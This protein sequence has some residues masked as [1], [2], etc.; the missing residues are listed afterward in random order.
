VFNR[1]VCRFLVANC[2]EIEQKLWEVWIEYHLRPQVHYDF[3]CD[4]FYKATIVVNVY[5]YPFQRIVPTL[6][7]NVQEK[8]GKISLQFLKWKM[9]FTVPI[10]TEPINVL[11]HYAAIS[12]ISFQSHKLRKREST[13]IS[14][15]TP[16][17]ELWMSLS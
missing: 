12:C 15:H 7:K 11:R 16:L 4:N 9:D 5:R 13:C 1:N 2:T 6:D 8:G 14:P 3:H 17:S 10:S